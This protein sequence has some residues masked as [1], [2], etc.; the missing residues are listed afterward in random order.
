MLNSNKINNLN[1]LNK[2]KSL[3]KGFKQFLIKTALFIA[4]FILF[5]AIIGTKLYQYGLL[6]KWKIEIYGRIGYILLFSIAGFILLYREKLLNLESFKYKI[7]DFLLLLFSFILLIIF[8]FFEINAYKIQLNILNIILVHFIGISIFIFLILG[9]YSL[10][11]INNFIKKFKKE[12]LYFL[13]FGII[14]ASLMSFVLSLWPYFSS[15]VLKL[16]AFLLSIIQADYTIFEPRTIIVKGFGAQIAEPCSGI[17]SIF[18]FT[19]LYIFIIFVDWKKINKKKAS[20]LFIPAIIGAFFI[21]VLRVFILFLVGAYVSKDIAM[22]MYHSYTGMIFFLLYFALF[23]LVFYKYIKDEKN[24]FRFIPEDSLYK[25]SIYLMIGTF[26]M[27]IFGFLFWMINARLFTAEQVGLAI[28][29]I[30]VMSLITSF[31]ALGLGAGLIR[32]LPNSER[33]NEKINTC[34]TLIAIVTIIITTFF[35][36]SLESFSPKLLFIKENV[37]LAFIFIIFMV[38]ASFNGLIDSIFLAYRS[39]KYTLLKNS[40]FSVLKIIFPFMLV[41]LGAYGIFGSYM[42]SLIIGFIVS[43]FVLI[44]KFD[45]KPRFVFYDKIIRK[46]GK[47]SFGNYVAGFIS[48]L[49]TLLLPLIIT[50][51]L[52]PETSAYYYMAMMIANVLF[53]IPQATSSSLFAEGS[54]NEKQLKY[55][56]KKAIKIISL[57]LIPGII[58]LIFFGEYGLLLLGEDY[59]TQGYMLLNLLAISGVFIGINSIFSAL[60]R[61]KKRIKTLIKINIFYAILILGL[62]YMFMIKGTSLLGIGYAYLIGQAIISGVYLMSWK[63]K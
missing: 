27:S 41:S 32:Y 56:V 38:F 63:R 17:Y 22:G 12:I 51:M 9:I 49:P 3:N 57:F 42:L 48:S 21:N 4:L 52:A 30:S 34:F 53:I 26:V 35:L 47:Y 7:K 44:Y 45:Y 62:S 16:V 31:S 19:A 6:D 36:L 20:I 5:S 23:W 43:V 10:D 37:V 50:N 24:P 61:V 15:L 2:L 59:S 18:L 8:Y 28:T 11:F 13:I 58:I 33:K 1:N 14:T 54:Y 60:L 55:L 39:A 29:I 46:I 40:V 25:N